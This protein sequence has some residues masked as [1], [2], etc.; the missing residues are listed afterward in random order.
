VLGFHKCSSYADS[1]ISAERANNT[2]F[3]GGNFA[4]LDLF[5]NLHFCRYLFVQVLL[6]IIPK[7]ITCETSRDVHLFDVVIFS[8]D[9]DL[10]EDI[11]RKNHNS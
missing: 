8:Q 6:I 11:D 2:Y 10:C 7:Q 1:G 9:A 3:S 4:I 5:V